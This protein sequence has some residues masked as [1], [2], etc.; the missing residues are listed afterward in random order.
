M[1]LWIVGNLL[2][3]GSTF[4]SWPVWELV[5]VFDDESKAVDA[6]TTRTHFV[7]PADLNVR[8]PDE[9]VEWPGH[10]YPH[11]IRE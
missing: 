9:T 2:N 3:D 4:G 10:Y 11:A 1:R 6:C 7:G 8:Q 5:G